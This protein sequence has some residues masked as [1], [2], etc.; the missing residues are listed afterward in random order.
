MFRFPAFTVLCLAAT[1]AFA[2]TGTPP[3]QSAPAGPPPEAMAAIQTAAAAFGQCIQTG[4]MSVP[5]SVTP[6][7]G[8]T[9][10]LNGCSTQRQ[11]VEQAANALIATMPAEQRPMAQE[12]LRS[13][14]GGV[15][16]QVV[17]G[18]TQ[19]RAAT[20]AAP[21]SAPAQ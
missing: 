4:V 17:A 21:A 18:I 7:A 12:Q 20:A 5:A 9:T 6:E 19:M 2:Q 8:A 16:A 10:V 11:A 13:Q 3:A 1:S 14:L 15:Q